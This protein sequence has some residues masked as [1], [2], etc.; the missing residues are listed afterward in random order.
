MGDY[1]PVPNTMGMQIFIVE[2]P[3]EHPA[4][5]AMSTTNINDDYGTNSNKRL[6]LAKYE[7]ASFVGTLTRARKD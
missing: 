1:L 2:D 4:R 3:D 6:E 7:Q 5:G